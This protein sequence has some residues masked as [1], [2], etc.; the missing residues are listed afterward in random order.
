VTDTRNLKES[1]MAIVWLFYAAFGYLSLLAALLWGML[2]FGG[3]VPF[4]NMDAGGIGAPLP[5]AIIDLALL[6]LVA[7]LHG[8]MSR[9]RLTVFKQ[10]GALAPS[11]HAWAAAAALASIYVFWQPLPQVLWVAAGPLR[12]VLSASF[13]IAWTLILIGTFLASHLTLFEIAE[14]ARPASPRA[15]DAAQAASPAAVHPLYWGV[16]IAAW[17]MPVMTAG[18]LLFAGAVTVYLLW[19]GLGTARKAADIPAH[20]SASASRVSA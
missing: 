10:P 4:P 20:S 9:G 5:A 11:T 2:F 7:F 16:L 14:A 1:N 12:W 13:Y 18:R 19:V 6:L 17:A 3:D 15:A 8:G